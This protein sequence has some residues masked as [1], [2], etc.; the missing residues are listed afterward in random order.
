MHLL[1]PPRAHDNM[2]S[3]RSFLIFDPYRVKNK[4]DAG[5]MNVLR[6]F[7]LTICQHHSVSAGGRN[8]DFDVKFLLSSLANQI[9]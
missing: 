4:E 3:T 6:M 9:V 1:E 7:H 2:S 5:I 8:F